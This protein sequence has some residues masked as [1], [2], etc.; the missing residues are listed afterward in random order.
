MRLPGLDWDVSLE[1]SSDADQ[2][3]SEMMDVGLQVV[4]ESLANLQYGQNSK[5]G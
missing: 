5:T 1:L 2:S 4:P 3:Q